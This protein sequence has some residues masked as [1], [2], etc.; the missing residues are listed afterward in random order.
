ML[1]KAFNTQAFLVKQAL[2]D[3]DFFIVKT[4]I[5]MLD[6]ERTCVVDEDLDLLILIITLTP[7]ENIVFSRRSQE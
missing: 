3:A 7:Q 1:K 6:K 5:E 2:N 4:G